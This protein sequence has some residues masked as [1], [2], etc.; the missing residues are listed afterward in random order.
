MSITRKKM[1][2]SHSVE[3]FALSA[4]QTGDCEAPGNTFPAS[5]GGRTCFHLL[6]R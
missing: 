1:T 2:H 4:S 5:K 3:A 6:F